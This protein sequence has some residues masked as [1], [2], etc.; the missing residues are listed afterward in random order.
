MEKLPKVEI[1][2]MGNSRTEILVNGEPLQGVTSYKLE[3]SG[4]EPP[5]LTLRMQG[6][7]MSVDSVMIPAL[8]KIFEGWY[9]ES[10]A[11]R[12]AKPINASPYVC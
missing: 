10:D 5:V 2:N 6:V 1:R 4:G 8:P 11:V 9:V 7:E 3:Q 12:N